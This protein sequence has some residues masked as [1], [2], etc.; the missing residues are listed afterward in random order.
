MNS[1]PEHAGNGERGRL[2]RSSRRLASNTRITLDAKNRERSP[3]HVRSQRRGRHWQ[4][5]RRP[6]SPFPA[7]HRA[8]C[9]F[10][11]SLR[12]GFAPCC[13]HSCPQSLASGQECPLHRAC[14]K[15]HKLTLLHFPAPVLVA[16]VPRVAAKFTIATL[17]SMLV[18]TGCERR[19]SSANIEVANRQQEIAAKRTSRN[20]QVKEGLALKEVESILGQPARVETEKRPILVQKNLEV[21]RWFYEQDGKTL[22]LVF[23]D[24]NLQGKIPSLV[25]P[26]S[27]IATPNV[28]APAVLSTTAS[29]R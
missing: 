24:G 15:F 7:R 13:G 3:V 14:E 28:V 9:W 2:A 29:Q 22:E 5:A 8:L 25:E 21:T 6:R 12:E 20:A 26:G 23:V 17:F 18:F 11:L 4:R 19:L 16:T 1:H 27:Q 10:R